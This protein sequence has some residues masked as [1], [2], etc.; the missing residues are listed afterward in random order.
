MLDIFMLVLFG[1]K[2]RTR[3]QFEALLSAAGFRLDRVVDVGLGT[4]IL[5][6]SAV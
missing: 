3:P 4:F 6:A 5:E 2:E 1:G